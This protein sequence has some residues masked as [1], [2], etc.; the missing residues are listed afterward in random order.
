MRDFQSFYEQATGHRPY[1]Y[2]ARIARDGLPDVVRAPTGAGKTGVILAWLW[3]RLHGPDPAGTPRR[4]VYALPQRSLVDHVSGSIRMWLVNLGLADEVAV[5]V[6][7]G[8]RS[9]GWGDWRENMHQP[10]IVV[11]DADLLV[12]K[13]LIRGYGMGPAIYPMDLGLVGN[14]AQWIIDEIQLCP[15]ATTTLRQV[16]GLTK[17]LGTA[18]PFGLTCMT[19]TAGS[20]GLLAVV[21]NPSFGQT[22]EVAAVERAGDLA[23]R[24]G[25]VRT[26]RRAPVDPGDYQSLAGFVRASHRAGTLTLVV[27]HGVLAAQE[28]YRLL[29]AGPVPC[30]LLHSQ[31]RGVERAAR[32]AAVMARFSDARFSDARASDAR[33]SDARSSDLI[34]VSAGETASGLDLTAAVVVAESAPWPS[35]V[36]VIGRANRSGALRDGAVWWL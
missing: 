1:G 9:D 8:S 33:S 11:G 36:R 13:V 24:T 28:V 3:R 22:V 12:S 31:F 34:V 27:L 7:L 20:D 30:A 6:V 17:V 21:D 16:A 14:G 4:L 25:A 5:H 19:A 26:I 23:A 35:M 15:Q 10:A 18:E 29:R 32:L 2:Q